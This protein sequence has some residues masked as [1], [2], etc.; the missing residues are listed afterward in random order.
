MSVFLYKF[1]IIIPTYNRAEEL[2]ECLISLENQTYKNFEV[3]IC[4]DGSND[5]SREIAKEFEDT[6]NVQYFWN[7]NWGGPARPRNIGLDS[8]K[9]EWICFLDSDDW[10]TKDRLKTIL[11]LDLDK[12]DF[13]YHD[14]NIFKKGVVN[15]KMTSRNLKRND[16]YH[17]M[18]FNLNAIPTSSTCIRSKYFKDNVRF[19]EQKEIIGVEDFQLWLILAEKRVRFHYLQVAL[20]FYRLGD[21]NITC[22]DE[23]QISRF[24]SLY[25]YFIDKEKRKVDKDKIGAALNYQIGNIL[26][27]KGDLSQGYSFLNKSLFKG[28]IPIKLRSINIILLGFRKYLKL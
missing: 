20:G 5:D 18:L 8:A 24:K 11:K 4:D 12:I 3:L 21:D 9:G 23:R 10:Y 22:H 1:S 28:T 2:K 26:I 27:R 25:Q 15:G 17:D 7:E 6:L 14:L 19:K 13:I 16:P